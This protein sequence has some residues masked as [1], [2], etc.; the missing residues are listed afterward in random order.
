MNSGRLTSTYSPSTAWA[1]V[2]VPACGAFSG[3]WIACQGDAPAV[4][5]AA[6]AVEHGR[7]G[8]EGPLVGLL[9]PQLAPLRRL[10]DAEGVL[11]LVELTPGDGIAGGEVLRPLVDGAGVLQVD[12]GLAD[13]GLDVHQPGLEFGLEGA[14]LRLVGEELDALRAAQGRLDDGDDPA[15]LDVIAH[16]GELAVRGGSSRPATGGVIHGLG[17]RRRPDHAGDRQPLHQVVRRDGPGDEPHL[18]LLLLEERHGPVGS[19]SSTASAA[20][21]AAASS[22]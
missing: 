19:S 13:L 22:A 15:R 18:P 11:G 9:Q 12:L 16:P 6:G 4:P 8:R 14:D 17:P 20:R 2:T 7:H 1:A 5:S 21:R 10:G 3:I